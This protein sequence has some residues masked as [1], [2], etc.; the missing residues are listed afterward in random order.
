MLPFAIVTIEY[1]HINKYVFKVKKLSNSQYLSKIIKNVQKIN[2]YKK[3]A[4]YFWRT[5]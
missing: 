3:S 4:F 1:T 5:H 2:N